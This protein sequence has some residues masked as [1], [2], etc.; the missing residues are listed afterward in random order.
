VQLRAGLG[1]F[2]DPLA[3]LEC[4]ADDQA[5]TAVDISADDPG[6]GGVYWYLLRDE[7]GGTWESGGSAQVGTRGTEIDASG[8]GCP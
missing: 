6:S 4:I 8:N 1:D 7:P 3:T 2:S 5:Q